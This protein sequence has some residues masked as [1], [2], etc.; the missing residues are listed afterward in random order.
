MSLNP[1]PDWGRGADDAG[2]L[3]G[4]KAFKTPLGEYLGAQAR[5]GFWASIP[6]QIG[7]QINRANATV[8]GET[9]LTAEEW[10]QSPSFRPTIPFDEKMTPSRARATAETFD[11]NA[12]NRW[13]IEQRKAGALDGTLGFIAG[14][15]GSAPDPVNFIPWVG[16]AFRAARI[17]RFGQIGGRA[18]AGAV[19]GA[20]GAA[21]A[22]PF[23]VTSRNQFGDDVG[24]ADVVTDIAFGAFAGAAIG[25]AHGVWKRFR[26][27]TA[28]PDDL[29]VTPRDTAADPVPDVPRQNAALY[30]LDGAARD[31]AAGRAIDIDPRVATELA[32]LRIV[33]AANDAEANIRIAA[34]V[35]QRPV[36]FSR[37]T[38]PAPIPVPERPAPAARAATP[39]PGGAP[40]AAEAEAWRSTPAKA[41]AELADA[42]L[43]AARQYEAVRTSES[44]RDTSVLSAAS[45][46]RVAA[47]RDAAEKVGL[48]FDRDAALTGALA[49]PEWSRLS[50]I[51]S[52][53]KR[54]EAAVALIDRAFERAIPANAE[55]APASKPSPERV[56]RFDDAAAH[57]DTADALVAAGRLAEA[58]AATLK[59]ARAELARAEAYDRAAPAAAFCFRG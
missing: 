21:V 31:L 59:A 25:G 6:G 44:A 58:D 33:R 49:S 40:R 42:I 19:E 2:I 17:A 30:T 23:L 9:P 48:K 10:R 12:Y 18:V 1:E 55:P 53:A 54:Q 14:I 43:T 37:A 35:E 34:G 28:A 39:E 7:A 5:E 32:G 22:Q 36:D 41:K 52:P 4:M 11:E 15:A 47:V 51:K 24:F 20:V 57:L 50:A 45:D 29:K 16:P 3:A 38:E 8:E 56:E 26:G 13:L 27:E 46:A